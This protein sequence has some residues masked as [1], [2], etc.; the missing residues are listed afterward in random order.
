MTEKQKKSKPQSNHT[1]LVHPP[2]PPKKK[3]RVS[4]VIK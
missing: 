1:E 2:A 3:G 4:R